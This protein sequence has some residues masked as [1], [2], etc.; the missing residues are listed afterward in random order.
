MTTKQIIK[1]FLLI[2]FGLMIPI[3]LLYF[4]FNQIGISTNGNTLGLIGLIIGGGS[5]AIAG[6]I[7]AKTS[8]K[9]KSYLTVLKEF[10]SLRQSLFAYLMV[11]FFLLLNF[12]MKFDPFPINKFIQLLVVSLIFGGIEEIGWRYMFQPT[13]EKKFSFVAATCLTSIAW[14]I[15]H[16]F[17]FILDGSLF[18]MTSLNLLIFLIGLA[19]NSFILASIFFTTNSLWLCVLYHASLNAFTQLLSS[20]SL[21]YSIISASNSILFACLFVYLKKRARDQ[22]LG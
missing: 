14:G 3:A 13:L 17:Y 18:S 20:S 4:I 10:F 1:Q 7:T 12:G 15:W 16:L 2:S 6:L 11:I 9:V 19:G 8:G 21:S 22:N 5:T